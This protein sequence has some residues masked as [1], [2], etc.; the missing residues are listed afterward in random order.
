[1]RSRTGFASQLRRRDGVSEVIAALMLVVIVVGVATAV[2]LFGL[3]V[4]H[5]LIGGGVNIPVTTSAQMTVPGSTNEFGVLTLSVRNSQSLAIN[6]VLVT[7]SAAFAT[8]ASLPG[9]AP[10]GGSIVGSSAVSAPAGAPFVAGT[11][12]LIHLTVRFANGDT[13]M[14][15]LSVTAVS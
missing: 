14:I 6:N 9:S 4:V 11:V 15:D 1:M 10:P 8:C 2:Y 5:S 12:Y 7:C 3:G 13:V